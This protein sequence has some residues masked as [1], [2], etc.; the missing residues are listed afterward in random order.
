MLLV[1]HLLEVHF[2][3]GMVMWEILER[4]DLFFGM[5]SKEIAMKVTAQGYRPPVTKLDSQRYN[6]LMKQCWSDNPE[7][8]PTFM[9]IV[10][11]VLFSPFDFLQLSHIFDTTQDEMEKENSVRGNSELIDLAYSPTEREG[12][13]AGEPIPPKSF[14]EVSVLFSDIV[15]FTQV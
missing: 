6:D 3:Q 4:K 12:I 5:G 14:P 1:I 15:G 13:V 11:K 8:R 10:P 7:N 2:S 9:Q